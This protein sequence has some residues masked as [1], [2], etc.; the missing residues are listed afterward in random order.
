MLTNSK[1]ALSIA[2]VLATASAATAAPKQAVRNQ[3]TI[4]QQVPA[5]AYLSF[6][7]V[8]STTVKPSNVKIQ[9]IGFNENL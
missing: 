2:L 7:S 3:T 1:I 9:D 8:R 6:G 5:N 4:Q